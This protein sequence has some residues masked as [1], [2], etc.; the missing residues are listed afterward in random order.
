MTENYEN[1]NWFGKPWWT[2]PCAVV[3]SYID[4]IWL[5]QVTGNADYLETAHQIYYNGICFEQHA[6]GGFACNSCSGSKNCQLGVFVEEAH[7]CCSM[8]GGEGLS[9]VAQYQAFKT[10]DRII[11]AQF[12]NGRYVF[13]F[14]R[15]SIVFKESCLYPYAGK[16]YLEVESSYMQFDPEIRLFAPSWINEPV[17]SVNGNI[18]RMDVNGRFLCFT[19]E[20]KDGDLIEYTFKMK[21]QAMEMQ[22]I[23]SNPSYHKFLYGP[24]LMGY[25]GK[26]TIPLS[27]DIIIEPITKELFKV[28]DQNLFLNPVCHQMN[29]KVKLDNY[30][31]QVLFKQLK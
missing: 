5:W 14:G 25:E 7:W 26:D 4:A 8:R 28:K 23:H 9:R 22:N 30:K 15:D 12:E 29:A 13:R 24:L 27:Q 17:V 20:L 6:N 21:T 19:Y 10:D 31:T 16:V 18:I 11:F 3:D 2:E 1:Y